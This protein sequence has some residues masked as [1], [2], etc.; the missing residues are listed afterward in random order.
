MHVSSWAPVKRALI[1]E[2]ESIFTYF[3]SFIDLPESLNYHTYNLLGRCQIN[4][5]NEEHILNRQKAFKI[6]H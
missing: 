3:V 5:I 6:K 1:I 2:S 4:G